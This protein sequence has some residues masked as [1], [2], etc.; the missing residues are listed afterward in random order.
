MSERGFVQHPLIKPNT[1]AKRLYQ[2]TIIGTALKWNTL[3]VLPTGVGKTVIAILEAA[4]QL[5]KFPHSKCVI[6]APTKPL[7]LQHMK[8]FQELMTVSEEQMHIITGE[9]NPKKR[10]QLWSQTQIAFMTPQVLQN[11][12]IAGRYDL[13]NVSLLVVDEAHRAVGEYA[14]VF[15]AGQYFKHAQSPLLLA[16]TA[17]PGSE[18]EKIRE[19]VTNLGITNIELRTRDSPDVAPYL[20]PVEFEW[21]E[22]TLPEAFQQVGKALRRAIKNRLIPIKEAALIDS[23]SPQSISVR[24]IL[25]LQRQIQQRIAKEPSPPSNLFQIVSHCAALIR[26][27]HCI[28][29]LETQGVSALQRY[30]ENLKR[31][32]RLGKAS[33][34]IQGLIQDSDLQAAQE[35]IDEL[36]SANIEHPK[37][38]KIFQL[39]TE[40]LE[41]SPK[42]RIMVF[43]RF[44]DTAKLLEKTLNQASNTRPIRFV[45]QASR[46]GDR[47]L[48]QKEQGE[49]LQ[50]FREGTYN[51]LVA[52]SVGEEG[53]DIQEC[54]LVIFYEAVPSAVRLIQRRGR[55]ART[56]PGRVIV[57]VALGTRD[58]GYYWASIH[59]ETK[60]QG[61]LKEMNAMSREFERTRKQ[62]TLK[63]FMGSKNRDPKPS[64]D[65]PVKI[66]VDTRELRSSITKALKEL[67]V[68]I[69][70]ETL[71]VGDYI[72][73]DRVAVE[74]KTP[75]D[76]AQSI[77]DRRLFQ[78]LS[79][80]KDNFDIPLLLITGPSLYGSSAINPAAIR[81][82]L[83]TAIT[84]FNVPVVN[85]QTHEEAAALLL[86]IARQ[87]QSD[88]KRTLSI[89][90]KK[91]VL[92][93]SNLQEYIVAGLPGV[94]TTLAKRLLSKFGTITAIVN[95]SSEKLAEIHGI[96]KA[97][98]QQMR[99]ALDAIYHPED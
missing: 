35:I 98:A 83:S 85:V 61:L 2:E 58:Q 71:E 66:I 69:E 46:R 8:T 40:Q 80:L 49:I 44:R 52:T 75:D 47:G 51:V 57:L 9:V 1:I 50:L 74:A 13:E 21:L 72:L 25:Q 94:N 62:S 93:I 7:V 28:E 88:R 79:A 97:K 67:N 63:E 55:T 68:L 53:L 5:H 19:I 92:S 24:Q 54:D 34:A 42:S 65:V 11:D 43:T 38:M 95:A 29:L 45:G 60:M 3:V 89:R 4:Y 81:G 18:I 37:L 23:I 14:Y 12:L 15:I 27:F 96:G 6:L 84:D 10:Q 31:E 48:T 64:E 86:A 70:V 36:I 16:L 82:A 17:S 77:I 20:P 33:K 73:S 91:P 39:V 41:V 78:Q 22:I 90:G 30:F 59:R 99:D 87:E 56:H 26:L 32:A 76:F